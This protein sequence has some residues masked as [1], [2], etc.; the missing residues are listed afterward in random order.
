MQ[1]AV[2]AFAAQPGLVE[3]HHLCGAE[4]GGDLGE[5]FAQV[6]GGAA[7]DGGNGPVGDRD[8]EQFAD[9]LGSAFLRQE[10]AHE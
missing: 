3:V 5:E 1:P 2:A 10:L 8:G 9:G 6:G 4:A 7:G